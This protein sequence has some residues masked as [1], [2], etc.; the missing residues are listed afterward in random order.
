MKREN[1]NL[2]TFKHFLSTIENPKAIEVHHP[3]VH[4]KRKIFGDIFNNIPVTYYTSSASF[5]RVLNK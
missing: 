1:H 5:T 3:N 4:E 2:E